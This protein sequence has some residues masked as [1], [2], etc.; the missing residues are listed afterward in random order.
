MARHTA[1]GGEWQRWQRTGG[2]ESI[3]GCSLPK[4]V[5][6]GWLLSPSQDVGAELAAVV[7]FSVKLQYSNAVFS[8]PTFYPFL[9]RESGLPAHSP[10]NK[11]CPEYEVLEN[12]HWSFD[13][14]KI[15]VMRR[16]PQLFCCGVLELFICMLRPSLEFSFLHWPSLLCGGS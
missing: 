13:S 6:G 15:S 9:L 8:V 4:L 2:Q 7:G 14:C 16:I 11:A 1:R 5:S 10:G 3:W 12:Y